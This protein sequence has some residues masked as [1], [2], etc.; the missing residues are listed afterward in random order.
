MNSIN[1]PP[2]TPI[3]ASARRPTTPPITILYAPRKFKRAPRLTPQFT[4]AELPHP[5]VV[6][7]VS[8]IKP[9]KHFHL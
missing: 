8:P 5:I 9:T 2:R 4:Y 6:V 7:T 1:K 3:R